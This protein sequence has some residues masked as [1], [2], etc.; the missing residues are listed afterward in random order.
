MKK[1]IFKLLISA[2]FISSIACNR[3]LV[4][5]EIVRTDNIEI[6]SSSQSNSPFLDSMIGFY[7][8]DMGDL[9]ER[10]L[11]ESE[12]QLQ[13]KRPESA[14]GNYMA[15]AVLWSAKKYNSDS[16]DFAFVNMGGIRN[17][18][19]KG[20]VTVRNVFELMPF[21]NQIVILELKGDQFLELLSQ[22]KKGGFEPQAGL[23]YANGFWI[24][25]GQQI[26]ESRHYNVAVSDYVASGGDSYFVLTKAVKR[27]NTG[28][29]IR[30]CIIAYF[31]YLNDKE[32][33]LSNK[34]TGRI[35]LE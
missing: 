35:N 9:L 29:A 34:Y 4:P 27:I 19:P 16:V 28:I 8:K 13:K 7:S 10:K 32:V 14:L 22:I 31:D 3:V 23:A 17:S 30:D 20:N 25:N 18:L 11:I 21:D 5:Q 24:L 33:K 6:D 15:D 26:N 2:T 1:S 12:D